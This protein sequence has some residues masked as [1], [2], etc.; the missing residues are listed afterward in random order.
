MFNLTEGLAVINSLVAKI[1]DGI[2]A[3]PSALV[4]AAERSATDLE[5]E[6]RLLVAT[7]NFTSSASA[8]KSPPTL[9][10]ALLT[11][12][13]NTPSPLR[14]RCFD[15]SCFASSTGSTE[16]PVFVKS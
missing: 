15:F 7:K 4:K 8:M 2:H 6:T 14:S 11:L 12:I 10:K 16:S 5:F 9:S 13:P 1:S 3:E